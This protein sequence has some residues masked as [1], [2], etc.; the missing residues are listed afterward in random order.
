[1]LD[2]D[3]PAGQAGM[4]EVDDVAGGVDVRVRGPQVVVDDDAVV[5]PQAR[6]VSASSVF[7]RDADTDH[8]RLRLDEAAC[9]EAYA[10]DPPAAADDLLDMH[11]EPQVDAV[12]AVQLREDR[13][14]PR[15]PSTL[16]RGSLHHLQQRHV[17]PGALRAA[18]VTSSPIQPARV[19]HGDPRHRPPTS[20]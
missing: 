8:D 7:G 16:S 19:D 20:P 11:A 15:G 14:P 1:M 4:L 2:A 13:P 17:D 5:D 6:S 12:A 3:P 10:R 9:G 18:A